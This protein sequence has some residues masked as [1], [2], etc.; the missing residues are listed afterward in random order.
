MTVK[1]SKEFIF[2]N[3]YRQI[4]F[5]IEKSYYSMIYQKKKYLLLLGTKLTKKYLILMMLKNT[6]NHFE[7]QKQKIVSSIKSNYSTTKNYRK[8]KN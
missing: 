1:E 8:P 3:Y 4:G 7:K 2:E 6:I 5:N